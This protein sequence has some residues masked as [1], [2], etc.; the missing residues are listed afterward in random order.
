MI[1]GQ[2]SFTVV[3]TFTGLSGSCCFGIGSPHLANSRAGNMV[4]LGG[5]G[6]IPQRVNRLYLRHVSGNQ[7]RHLE[8]RH[9]RQ[10]GL[11]IWHLQMDRRSGRRCR[12][13]YVAAW[14]SAGACTAAVAGG[15]PRRPGHCAAA[16]DLSALGASFYQRP[17]KSSPT[18]DPGTPVHQRSVTARNCRIAATPIVQT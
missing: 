16:A 12:S 4:G 1:V 5:T 15:G 14:R 18:T 9:V 2:T 6:G 17:F 3:N 13:L 10:P 7:H 8:Q 11:D